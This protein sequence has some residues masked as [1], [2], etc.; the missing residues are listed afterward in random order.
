LVAGGLLAVYLSPALFVRR[1]VNR[2]AERVAVD[3]SMLLGSIVTVHICSHDAC[4]PLSP[5]TPRTRLA[6][7]QHA[8]LNDAVRAGLRKPVAA[9]KAP[10]FVQR[11]FKL[12]RPLV[13]LTKANA[14][15]GEPEDADLVTRMQ[16]SRNGGA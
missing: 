10:R 5:S 1:F 16:R 9:T 8:P 13:D 7:A 4:E 6:E 2:P 11:S 15:A 14:L 3:A 12:G